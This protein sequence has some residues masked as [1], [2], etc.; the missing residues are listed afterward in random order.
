M[1]ASPHP[2]PSMPWPGRAIW[3]ASWPALWLAGRV[4]WS[5]EIRREAAPPSPPFV[6]A[7]NH[8]SHLDPPLVG[9]ALRQPVT[10][11]ALD[12][13]F[14]AHALLDL[15]LH[16]FGTVPVPRGKVALGALRAA[17]GH[18]QAGRVVG[19]FP[20]GRRV[21]TWGDEPARRGAAWLAVRR[22]VPL[23]PVAV[24]GTHR[25]LGVDRSPAPRP[26]N[27]VAKSPPGPPPEMPVDGSPA[28]R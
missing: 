3:R 4:L 17:L 26:P 11:L 22:E 20:E 13:L 23:V 21:A 6:V 1:R 28:P 19:L 18:L 5:L 9:V 24:I 10:F 14:G 15:A 16:T 2:V 7:A 27:A 25:V 12:E 8:F